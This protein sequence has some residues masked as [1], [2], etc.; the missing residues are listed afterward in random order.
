VTEEIQPRPTN[1]SWEVAIVL[2]GGRVLLRNEIRTA[3]GAFV[4]YL[5]PDLAREMAAKLEDLG[6]RAGRGIIVP[7]E[8]LPQDPE[9]N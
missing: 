8:T 9:R 1:L 2:E 5:P 3:T 4:F 7:R 6:E